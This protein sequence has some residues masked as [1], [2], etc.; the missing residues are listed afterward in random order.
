MKHQ[1]ILSWLN[2]TNNSKLVT[3]K[4]NISNDNLKSNFD[5]TNEITYNTKISKSIRCDYDDAFI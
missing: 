1:K 2:E 3:R 5:A 4:W